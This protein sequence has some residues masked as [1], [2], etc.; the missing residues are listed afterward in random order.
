MA[1]AEFLEDIVSHLTALH[2][3]QQPGLRV[4]HSHRGT[5]T[6]GRQTKPGHAG[7]DPD[8]AT[9]EAQPDHFQGPDSRFHRSEPPPPSMPS[10]TPV[11]RPGQDQ[12][13]SLRPTDA[14]QVAGADHRRATRRVTRSGTS[15][16]R[17]REQRLP[18]CRRVRG[19]THGIHETRRP[20]IVLFVNGIPLAVIECKRPDAEDAVEIGISQQLRNQRRDE[21][22]HLFIFSQLL[23]VGLPEP[24]EICHGGNAEE[25]LV[26]MERRTPRDLDT[27]LAKLINTPLSP[28]NRNDCIESRPTE[29]SGE[30]EGT[31]QGRPP[32]AFTPG[33]I[34]V[35]P[36]APGT[37]AGTDLPIHAIRQEHQENCPLPAVSSRSARR[38]RG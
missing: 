8:G 14:G 9:R 25:V 10:R 5:G 27:I 30:D 3:L 28:P 23:L 15:T 16:G 19:R 35:L 31:G 26:G 17:T 13:A 18:C 38:W 1:V 4:P 21:I 11:R 36:A 7:Y 24:G 37:A 32:S 2:L 22:P 20:D 34:A 29:D 12:R 33:P 6:S